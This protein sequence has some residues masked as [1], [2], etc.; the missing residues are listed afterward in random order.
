[1][2]RAGPGCGGCGMLYMVWKA[3]MRFKLKTFVSTLVLLTLVVCMIFLISVY[4]PKDEHVVSTSIFDNVATQSNV[5]LV[6][7]W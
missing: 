4:W 3:K 1:M 5:V 2:G 6:L 7:V